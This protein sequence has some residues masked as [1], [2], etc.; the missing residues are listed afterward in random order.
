VDPDGQSP[1]PG[2]FVGGALILGF[3]DYANVPA[4]G[5]QGISKP[6][7]EKVLT[8]VGAGAVGSARSRHRIFND[9]LEHFLYRGFK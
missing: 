1:V 4:L 8:I 9:K 7:L 2:L 3:S 6:L 5:E